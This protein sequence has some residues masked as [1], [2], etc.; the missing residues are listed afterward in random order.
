MRRLLTSL[1]VLMI[2]M[3]PVLPLV[4]SAQTV[5]DDQ[6]RM[7]VARET[8][9]QILDSAVNGDYNAFFDKLHPDVLAEVPRD[10]A[11]QAFAYLYGQTSPGPATITDVKL[12]D[13]TWPVNDV[14]Y[15]NTAEITYTQT[16]KN[17]QGKTQQGEFKMYLTPV[18]GQYRWFFGN[19]SA[20][21]NE[22]I[23]RF[24]KPPVSRDGNDIDGL[25]SYVVQDLDTFFA[26]SFDGSSQSYRSP[27]VRVVEQGRREMTG[28]GPAAAGFWAFYCPMDGTVWLDKKFLAE[29]DQDFGDF[30]VAFVIGHE[31]AHHVQTVIGLDR[32]KKP[33]A[34]MD[35]YSIELELMADCL[36]GVWTRD[37]ETRGSLDDGDLLEASAFIFQRLGDPNGINPFNEQA[38][39][40]GEQ[41][42]DAFTDGF[43]GGFSA[44]TPNGLS[45]VRE[46]A[47]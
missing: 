14:T 3:L 40:N 5:T 18:D 31:W 32:Q 28:C 42:I 37:L 47:T 12:G 30:A 7:D 20:Y 45:P 17:Q 8:A 36:G 11:L 43:D 34:P 24:A 46:N 41:R 38:H 44:C 23:A 25:I 26:S 15:P 1:M 27:K 35:V 21:I 33:R 10:V 2:G 13:Y 39:G 16:F 4:A 6:M 29:L 22:L 19:S 9:Q